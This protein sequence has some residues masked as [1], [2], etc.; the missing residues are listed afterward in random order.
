M[1]NTHIISNINL[2]QNC[3]LK[4]VQFFKV[5]TLKSGRVK[6]FKKLLLIHSVILSEGAMKVI[7]FR[8]QI[9]RCFIN[10]TEISDK[11]T[12]RL[13]VEIL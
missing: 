9:G 10:A 7:K 2:N 8:Y 5:S 11:Q 6:E 1:V 4:R 12:S 13:H 3:K